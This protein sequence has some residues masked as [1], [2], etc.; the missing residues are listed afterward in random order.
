MI[1]RE[2]EEGKEGKGGKT[3]HIRVDVS[4]RDAVES[5]PLSGPLSG[6]RLGKGSNCGFR[7]L[8]KT[9][10]GSDA[11]GMTSKRTRR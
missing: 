8:G 4:R 10:D 1:Q 5:E 2:R 6:E 3:H 7:L 11:F 9:S